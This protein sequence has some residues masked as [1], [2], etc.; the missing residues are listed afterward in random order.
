[1]TSRVEQTTE[2]LL[3]VMGSYSEFGDKIKLLVTGSV[4]VPV[5]RLFC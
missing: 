5:V 2:E 1:M 3:L 4:N